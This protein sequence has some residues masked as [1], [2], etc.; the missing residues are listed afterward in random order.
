MAYFRYVIVAQLLLKKHQR[1]TDR[2]KLVDILRIFASRPMPE[3]DRVDFYAQNGRSLS[4]FSTPH[5]L[6]VPF[7]AHG[8]EISDLAQ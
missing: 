8:T 2:N 6:G 4:N 5:I 7:G 1:F 3:A